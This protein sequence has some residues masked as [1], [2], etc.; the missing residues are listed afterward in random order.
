MSGYAIE[1]AEARKIVNNTMVEITEVMRIVDKFHALSLRPG[2][3]GRIGA[4]VAL[5]TE[6]QKWEQL[7]LFV[8]IVALM[9]ELQGLISKA[10]DKYENADLDTKKRYE[11]VVWPANTA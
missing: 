10:A 6:K 1:P 5:G 11:Q 7:Q 4:S 2:S 8:K 9:N 3:F